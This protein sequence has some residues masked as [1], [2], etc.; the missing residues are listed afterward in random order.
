MKRTYTKEVKQGKCFVEG[1]VQDVRDLSKIKFLVL[2]DITGI[3]QITAHKDKTKK[4]VFDII[5]KIPRESVISIEGEAVKSKQ[6]PNGIEIFPEKIS[7]LAEA[8][9]KLPIDISD[10]SKT[11]LPKRLDW[12]FLDLHNRKVQ[13][14]FKIQ[15]EI[16]AAFRSFWKDRGFIEINTPCIISSASEGGTELFPVMYFEKPAFLAQSPQLY[17]Q[18]CVTA[19]EKVFTIVPV[20]RA[21]PSHTV[22]HV[23]EARQMDIEVA[24]SDEFDVM[25]L[26]TKV[27]AYIVKQVKTKCKEELKSLGKELKIPKAKYLSYT[28]TIKLLKKNKI[29]VEQGED[30]P[31]EGEKKLSE[32][33]PNTIIFTYDW[34]LSLKP[35][36]IMPKD[37]KADAKLSEGF[38]A[39]YGGI[40]IS[41]GGQRVHIPELLI[42]RLKANKLDPK[43]FDYYI[44][45]FKYGAPRH[46]GWSIG[47]ERFTMALLGLENIREATL[48]PRDV[49]RLVP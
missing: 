46:A 14:I 12:R 17:K 27:V 7:V 32:I 2:R 34:P 25:D 30:I 29:K 23:T 11:E 36:Y 38:D 33:Y 43:K 4:E 24:F 5:T 42:K 16:A 48:F 31:P 28:D 9:P 1:F 3:V 49:E 26:L 13:A 37:E 15:S 20:W 19:L 21:E 47:L 39:I 44:N 45:S 8:E 22:R 41:S 35:F 18:M 10:F 6:A 40:E